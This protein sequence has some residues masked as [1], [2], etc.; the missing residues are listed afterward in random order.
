M[1]YEAIVYAHVDNHVYNTTCLDRNFRAE[2]LFKLVA[3]VE[4]FLESVQGCEVTMELNDNGTIEHYSK[5]HWMH[6]WANA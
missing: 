1:R 5:A 6:N 4:Q 3:L 2:S